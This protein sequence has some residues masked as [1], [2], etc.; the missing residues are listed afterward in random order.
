M[1]MP[2]NKFFIPLNLAIKNLQQPSGSCANA[3]NKP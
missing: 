1:S 2:T 3:I